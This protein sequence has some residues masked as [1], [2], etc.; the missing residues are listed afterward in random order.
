MQTL[1]WTWPWTACPGFE[2][3]PALSTSWCRRLPWHF[4]QEAQMALRGPVQPWLLFDNYYFRGLCTV[5]CA[6]TWTS[7]RL[8]HLGTDGFSVIN[9]L[10]PIWATGLVISSRLC[11][12]FRPGASQQRIHTQWYSTQVLQTYP[13]TSRNKHPLPELSITGHHSLCDWTM[14]DNI[15]QYQKALFLA[16]FFQIYT[17]SGVIAF[18]QHMPSIDLYD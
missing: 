10:G 17:S 1:D 15:L 14:S 4:E 18:S 6:H 7:F 12:M 13:V 5:S 8:F 9:K 2:V 11:V 3:A 16:Y